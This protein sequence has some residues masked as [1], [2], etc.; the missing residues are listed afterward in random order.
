MIPRKLSKKLSQLIKNK[1]E[2]NNVILLEG[3]RQVGKTTLIRQTLK[4]NNIP[5]KEVNLEENQILTEKIDRCEDFGAFTDLI[6]LEIKFELGGPEILFIDEAQESRQLGKFVRFMKEKWNWTQ[7]ILTGSSMARI[8]RGDTRFPVGRVTFLHLQPLSFS[9]FLT[10]GEETLSKGLS[11]AQNGEKISSVLHKKSLEFL[12]KY[13]EVGGLPE[14]VTTYLSGGDWRSLRSNILFGYYNDFKRAFGEEKQPYLIASMQA[15]ADLL[16]QPFKNNYVSKIMDG[17]KN[18]KI[19][20][21]LAQLESW[22]ILFKISQEGPAPTTDFHPKRYM[23][24]LGLAKQL[25]EASTPNI[26]LVKMLSP[27][28]RMPLG[29]T[30]KNMAMLGLV[31]GSPNLCGWK[32]SSS[33]SEVDFIVKQGVKTIPFECKSAHSIKNSHLYGLLDYMDM[34]GL[35]FGVIVSLA[36]LETRELI[37]NRRILILPLYLIEYWDEFVCQFSE[38]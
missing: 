20:E 5:F 29:G 36:E 6:R 24:D 16:G 19:V 4:E 10:A 14:V 9:E 32:K 13:I 38:A 22:K 37:K 18:D 15:T 8:F 1:G 30:I 28:A 35:S 12:E 26:G 3:A 27:A 7:V 23:F 31:D 34:Y 2:F 33:G 11:R 17:G 25:R 21:A